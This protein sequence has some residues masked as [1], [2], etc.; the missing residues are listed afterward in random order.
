[1]KIVFTDSKTVISGKADIEVLNEFGEVVLYDATSPKE[2]PERIADADMA[3]CNKTIFSAEAMSKAKKL[4]YIGLC[5]T[6]YN[7]IDVGYAAEHGITVC[8]A[9]SYSTDAVA[10]H[11]FALMLNR[12]SRVS[13]YDRFVSEG[14]WKKSEVFSPMVYEMHEISGK[15][16]GIVGFGSIGAAVAKIAAAF[17]MNVIVYTRTPKK[18]SNA[19]AVEFVGF[20]EL[21]SRSDIVT[22][23]CPLNDQSDRMFNKEAFA[24]C[25]KGAFFINTARGGIVDEYALKNALESEWLSGAAV[26]TISVEPMSEDCP[27]FG[28]KNL[29]ITPHI[30]WSP[31]ET[32]DRLIN[33][34][35][36]NIRCYLNGTPKNKVN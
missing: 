17:G 30:A 28:V 6:G 15:T 10:Q 2:L 3:L 31:A 1:M 21:L 23:H 9:G 32:I 27:L 18:H 7:N 4:K 24:K 16:L 29:T 12:F 20:D 26:D 25:K 34:V 19:A 13:E 36:D 33:I 11:T 5:A 8:N 22:V 35:A 14:S